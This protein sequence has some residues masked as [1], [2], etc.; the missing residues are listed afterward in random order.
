[1]TA[2]DAVLKLIERYNEQI[3]DYRRSKYKEAQ[4]RN[5]FI[6]PFFAALGWDVHNKQGYAEAYKEVIHEDSLTVG[7]SA[8]AP[9]YCF[10]VGGT[11]KFFVEAKKP[12]VNIKDAPAPTS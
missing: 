3:E 7:G 10:R 1:M 5:E 6:D 9:D 2:P 12:S 4:V 8:K 11:Q